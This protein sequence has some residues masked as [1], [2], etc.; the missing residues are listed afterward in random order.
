M[1]RLVKKVLLAI[2]ISLAF[3][4]LLKLRGERVGDKYMTDAQEARMRELEANTSRTPG[5]EAVFNALLA[6]DERS[7]ELAEAKSANPVPDPV[8]VAQSRVDQAA[9]AYDD[10]EAALTQAPAPTPAPTPTPA[11]AGD[12][13]GNN[14]GSTGG[15]NPPAAL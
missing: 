5:E 4:H 11:P 14:P 3:K 15:Q 2:S 13:T 10:A 6:L 9:K 8:A 1:K 12:G 7:E